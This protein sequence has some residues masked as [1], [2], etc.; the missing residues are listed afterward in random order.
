[1]NILI[2]LVVESLLFSKDAETISCAIIIVY[3]PYFA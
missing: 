3:L 1:M 2:S